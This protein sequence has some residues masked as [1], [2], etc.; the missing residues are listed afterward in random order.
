MNPGVKRFDQLFS[1][2]VTYPLAR[3]RGFRS[4]LSAI[5]ACSSKPS[6]NRPSANYSTARRPFTRDLKEAKA[7]LDAL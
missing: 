6:H 7:L 1:I 2:P 5:G 3:R 4:R